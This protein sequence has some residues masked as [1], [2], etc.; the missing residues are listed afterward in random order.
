MQLDLEKAICWFRSR[1]LDHQV[2]RSRW[3]RS[4]PAASQLA[5]HH[6]PRTKVVFNNHQSKADL[7]MSNSVLEGGPLRSNIQLVSQ[8][9]YHMFRSF[10][11]RPSCYL[12]STIPQ[13]VVGTQQ[14][15]PTAVL[16]WVTS[17]HSQ[18]HAGDP[19]GNPAH[20]RSTRA[21]PRWCC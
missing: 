14:S 3:F 17:T 19:Q 10:P 4:A 2:L 6:L 9:T 11:F 16:R 5:G 7:S 18:P 1:F 15:L 8:K 13:A 12:P 21:G 20:R